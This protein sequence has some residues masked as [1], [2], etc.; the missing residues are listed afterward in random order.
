MVWV[1]LRHS[2][3][4]ERKVGFFMDAEDKQQ[5][6]IIGTLPG[7]PVDSPEKTKGFD[8]RTS[9]HIPKLILQRT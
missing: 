4:R 9:T 6:V 7:V 5:P 3:W 1:T 2:W 8:P